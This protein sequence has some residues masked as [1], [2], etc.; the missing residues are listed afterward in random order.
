MYRRTDPDHPTLFQ[1]NL[2]ELIT[3]L[4][5]ADDLAQVYF[6][7][8][9]SSP[10]RLISW[11]G[12]YVE[13]SLTSSTDVTTVGALLKHLEEML[14]TTV[15]GYKGGDYAVRR[16]CPMWADD[17]SECPGTAIVGIDKSSDYQVIIQTWHM[18]F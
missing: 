8:G 5:T 13:M 14:G 10:G 9:Y 15:E 3:L 16:D 7:Y 2:G 1:L 6:D 4:A 11:R 18:G 17:Y 12:S